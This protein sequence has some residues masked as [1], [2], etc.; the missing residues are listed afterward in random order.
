MS[1]ST[2]T[3]D[4]TETSSGSGTRISKASPRLQLMGTT[5]E[6]CAILGIAKS[7]GTD[8][9]I[10]KNLHHIQN[11][12]F[13]LIAELADPLKKKLKRQISPD[14][15]SYLETLGTAIEKQLPRIDHFIVYGEDKVSAHLDFARAVARRLEREVIGARHVVE[16]SGHV[17]KFL[18]RLSDTLYL[19]AR[20]NDLK[21]NKK[22][23]EVRYD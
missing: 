13:V 4:Y 7:E 8:A 1:I 10:K 18:N 12:L 3:G 21:K 20:L 2:K 11:M 5:D 16:I 17:L 9:G 14:D 6:L 15:L 19:L 22:Y 23:R